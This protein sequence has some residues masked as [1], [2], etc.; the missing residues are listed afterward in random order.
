MAARPLRGRSHRGQSRLRSRV[1]IVGAECIPNDT[2]NLRLVVNDKHNVFLHATK[3]G[4][5]RSNG[6]AKPLPNPFG[7]HTV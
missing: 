3:S 6:P 2:S 5:S 7:D 4:R 1:G